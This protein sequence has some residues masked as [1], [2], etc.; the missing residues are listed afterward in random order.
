MIYRKY[1]KDLR[2]E[3]EKKMKGVHQKAEEVG[4][5]DFEGKIKLNTYDEILIW[6]DNL[7]LYGKIDETRRND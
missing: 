3:I 6:I 7:M 4:K 5:L 1:L 2:T